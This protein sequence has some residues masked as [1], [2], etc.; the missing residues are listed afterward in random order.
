MKLQ[1]LDPS[2]PFFRPLWRRVLT[3]LLP[4]IWA[5]VEFSNGETGWAIAFLAISAYAGYE[6]L[7]RYDPAKYVV[8]ESR[9]D[10]TAPPN[11]D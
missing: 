4:A 9:P 3:V 11:E 5:L 2:H 10:E 1:I 6:L 8:G 7:I